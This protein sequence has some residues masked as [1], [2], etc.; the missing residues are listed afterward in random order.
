MRPARPASGGRRDRDRCG[1][2]QACEA[3]RRSA[4]RPCTPCRREIPARPE[5]AGPGRRTRGPGRRRRADRRGGRAERPG[6]PPPSPAPVGPDRECGAVVVVAAPGE[7]DLGRELEGQRRP[8]PLGRQEPADRTR[9]VAERISDPVRDEHQHVVPTEQA[10]VGCGGSR[11]TIGSAAVREVAMA[12]PSLLPPFRDCQVRPS[13]RIKADESPT[14][15]TCTGRSLLS[16][17]RST[18]AKTAV[19]A[20]WRATSS[21]VTSSGSPGCRD[22]CSRRAP[23]SRM[24]APTPLR[25]LAQSIS[26]GACSRSSLARISQPC[27][28]TSAAALWESRALDTP[29]ETA[30]TRNRPSSVQR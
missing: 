1:S 9:G 30:Q 14:V 10:L 23:K 24:T 25:T 8:R 2:S 12:P 26:S 11:D 5:G 18:I 7:V 15:Q 20:I 28:V 29:S 4:G 19:A 13:R 16:G 6:P 3:R 21:G 17:R 27:R 22:F